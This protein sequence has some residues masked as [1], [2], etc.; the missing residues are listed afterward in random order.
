V[1]SCC[2]HGDES[3]NSKNGGEFLDRL[4]CRPPCNDPRHTESAT[5]HAKSPWCARSAVA[6]P[7]PA[8]HSQYACAVM[9][10]HPQSADPT[11]RSGCPNHKQRR[12]LLV[13]VTMAH[14]VRLPFVKRLCQLLPIRGEPR[15]FWA[16]Q[17]GGGAAA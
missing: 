17:R 5:E 3:C 9:S 12:L 6:P 7:P 14:A 10:A 1:A 16:E 4:S 2:E 11:F 13:A 15:D 8:L